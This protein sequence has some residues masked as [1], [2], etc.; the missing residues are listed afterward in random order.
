MSSRSKHTLLAL[1]PEVKARRKS[2]LVSQRGTSWSLSMYLRRLRDHVMGTCRGSAFGALSGGSEAR[3]ARLWWAMSLL[4]RDSFL[5]DLGE[6]LGSAL[7]GRG[8]V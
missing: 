7:D 5:G 1:T 6:S 2:A 8:S 4:E 3:P